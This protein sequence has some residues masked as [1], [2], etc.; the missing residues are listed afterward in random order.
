MF[1]IIVE[2]S[3][4]LEMN[5]MV[6]NSDPVF[7]LPE[8]AMWGL[9]VYFYDASVFSTVKWTQVQVHCSTKSFMAFE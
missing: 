4:N 1:S 6:E 7:F 9:R 2:K 3:G 8:N 5:S